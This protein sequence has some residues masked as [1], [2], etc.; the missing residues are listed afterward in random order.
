MATW[1]GFTTHIVGSFTPR[2][3]DIIPASDNPSLTPEDK[4][5][6]GN[7]LI[8]IGFIMLE[9]DFGISP[10]ILT[11]CM[12]G[13]R[14]AEATDIFCYCF[15]SESRCVRAPA[16]QAPAPVVLGLRADPTLWQVI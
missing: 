15:R 11:A 14:I 7:L 4:Q 8:Q 1:K 6:T 10:V 3:Q 5:G 16:C 13:C 12:N 2:L 9:I